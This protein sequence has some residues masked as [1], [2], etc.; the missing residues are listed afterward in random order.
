MKAAITEIHTQ[1]RETRLFLYLRIITVTPK[2]LR[3]D[4]AGSL[5]VTTSSRRGYLLSNGAYTTWC[6]LWSVTRVATLVITLLSS[7]HILPGCRSRSS[8]KHRPTDGGFPW[9]RWRSCEWAASFSTSQW[10]V[11]AGKGSACRLSPLTRSK[12]LPPVKHE[13]VGSQCCFYHQRSAGQ[14]T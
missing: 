12:L 4:V 7:R 13:S 5:R 11:W 8:K 3:Y 14:P 9:A 1:N 10:M 6:V 2:N